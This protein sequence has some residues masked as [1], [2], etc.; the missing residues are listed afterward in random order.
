[1]TWM[2]LHQNWI[3]WS[4]IYA[5]LALFLVSLTAKGFVLN[6]YC[7]EPTCD[8]L[9][10]LG[11]SLSTL[12]RYPTT[13]NLLSN[14]SEGGYIHALP[15]LTTLDVSFY[16][17]SSSKTTSL[18]HN[19]QLARP[20]VAFWIPFK[21]WVL[22]CHA[23]NDSIRPKSMTYY[24]THHVN[25]TLPNKAVKHIFWSRSIYIILEIL[26]VSTC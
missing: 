7:K 8:T 17:C 1:M 24:N 16:P 10:T 2:N 25:C 14:T 5:F 21:T 13:T 18:P 22:S 19:T 20:P 4:N 9:T 26:A 6:W 15:K 3:L 12:L 11:S 23:V